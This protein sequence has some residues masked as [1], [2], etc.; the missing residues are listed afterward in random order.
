MPIPTAE[1]TAIINLA[2]NSGANILVNALAGTGKTST[3]EMVCN[4]VTNIPILYLA[5]NKRIVDEA[6]KRMPS[7]VECRTQNSLGH[8][9]WA[10][11]TGRRLVVDGGKMRQILK[12]IIS[13]LPRK[14][15]GEAWEDFSDTLRW[16]SRAKRD[17]Y[18]PRDWQERCHPI[19]TDWQD[20]IEA[21]D[22]IEPTRQQRGLV[23]RALHFS[24]LAAHEG[25][26]DFDDQIYMPVI[27]GGRDSR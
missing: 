16:I 5:F 15:Q 10:Q 23:E 27:F 8:R 6:A 7:H 22:D 4:A 12:N 13:D 9:V 1:Q 18:I 20:F 24:I 2:R 17:G 14:D 25:G 3:I 21:Q 11:A 26:I 19:M